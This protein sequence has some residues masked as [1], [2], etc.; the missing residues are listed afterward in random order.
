M[1]GRLD[2]V[3]VV[4][5]AVP[6]GRRAV[7]DSAIDKRPV[8]GPIDVYELG[9]AGDYSLDTK[10]HGGIDQAVYVYDDAEARRWESELGRDL[11]HGWFGENLRTSGIPVT[12]AV[13]GTRWRIGTVLLEATIPRRPCGTFARWADEPRWVKRFGGRGDVGAYFRVLEPGILQRGNSIELEHVP[14]HNVTVRDLFLGSS[15]GRLLEL[16]A[17]P[18]LSPKVERDARAALGILT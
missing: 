7:V 8:E 13:V 14:S 11:P 2:A 12:D 5:A 9:L 17:T 6:L 16:L 1:T 15:A 10:F 4:H 3:C 18:D